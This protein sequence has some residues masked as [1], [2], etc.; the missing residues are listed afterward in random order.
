MGAAT[1]MTQ[2]APYGVD[3][4]L[5][6]I[7]SGPTVVVLHDESGAN[8]DAPF[9][10][11]LAERHRVLLPSHPGFGR[12]SVPP[13]FDSVDDLALFYA[14]LFDELGLDAYAVVGASFGGWIAA[15]LAVRRLPGLERLVLIDAVGIR[16]GGIEDRDIADVFALPHAEIARRLFHDP[17]IARVELDFS[18]RSDDELEMIARGREALARY[19]WQPFLHNPRLRARLHRIAVPTLVAWGASDGI[20]APDYGRAY[21]EAIPGARFELIER[22]GHLPHVE[23]PEPVCD[24]VLDFLSQAR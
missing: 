11:R 15:E 22:A 9:I 5:V 3:L 1:A 12:S 10:R 16:V 7:G 20:V 2:P 23:R 19:A 24:L 14:E 8:A 13:D 6:E 17:E 21:A 18:T 4:E